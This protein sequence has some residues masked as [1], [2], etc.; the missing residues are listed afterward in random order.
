MV[1]WANHGSIATSG[2]GE[3]DF[4][5]IRGPLGTSIHKL[6]YTHR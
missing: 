6:F 1:V 5:E 3:F 4:W 2:A